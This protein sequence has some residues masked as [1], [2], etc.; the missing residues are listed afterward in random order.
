[1]FN[2]KRCADIVVLF[3]LVLVSVVFS[4]IVIYSQLSVSDDWRQQEND[5]IM[6]KSKGRIIQGYSY[7]REGVIVLHLDN[8]DLAIEANDSQIN[9]YFTTKD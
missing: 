3:V 5:R 7:G 9:A 8:G 1:M 6:M 2:Q 4:A